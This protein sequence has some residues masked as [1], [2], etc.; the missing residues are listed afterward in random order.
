MPKK[1][2]SYRADIIQAMSLGAGG[3]TLGPDDPE[4][5]WRFLAEGDSWFTIGAIPSSNLLYE[6]R[7]KKRAIVLNLGYPGDTI[8]NMSQLSANTE[9]ARRLVHPN[10]A[11]DWD[12]ILLSGGGNDLIDRAA[13]II[14]S[15][16]SGMS[17][18]DYVDSE[19]LAAFGKDIQAG[20]RRIVALRDSAA[21]PN[22]G[23]PIVVHT[24]EYPTPRPAPA[25]FLIVPITKPWMHPVFEAHQVP[26]I[27]WKKVAELLLDALAEALLA[28]EK[29]LSAFH[30]VDTRNSLQRADI[31]ARGNSGDWLNEI[32]PNG[33]GYRKIAAQLGARIDKV[34]QA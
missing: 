10:W 17:A 6:L 20:Y 34:L 29:E 21:S 24:Y 22:K 16:P 26:K 27:L 14:L 30:V 13:D 5:S 19:Q 18:A 33:D 15:N 31:D 4:Y 23:K 28:L 12:A 32:H 1:T 8:A 2:V 11:S 9:F 25:T 7:L 3:A